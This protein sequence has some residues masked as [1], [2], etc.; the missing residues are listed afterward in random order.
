MSLGAEIQNDYAYEIYKSTEEIP[1][2]VNPCFVVT[3]KVRLSYTHLFQPYANRNGGEAKYSTTIL[4]PKSDTA[5]K[6]R[7][8]AA[9]A[10]AKQTGAS[11]CWNGDIPRS[12]R[13][14]YTMGMAPGRLTGCLSAMSAR[15]TGFSRPAANSR[16]RWWIRRYSPSST[17]ARSTAACTAVCPSPSS[18]TTP[19]AKRGSA[20]A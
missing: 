8:D 12:S 10:A 6:Q 9:I 11:K 13:C 1:M 5:T 16:R 14:R 17:R 4:V 15:A 19:M 7:I 2:N 3:G 20:A 18:P